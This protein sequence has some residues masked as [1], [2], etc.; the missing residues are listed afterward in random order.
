[1]KPGNQQVTARC[2]FLQIN[3][4]EMRVR[5]NNLFLSEGVFLFYRNLIF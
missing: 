5:C 1:M 2:Q 4:W 3:F